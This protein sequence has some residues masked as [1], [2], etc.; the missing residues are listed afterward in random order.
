M[1]SPPGCFESLVPLR[2]VLA[3]NEKPNPAQ[4]LVP[5]LSP[6]QGVSLL[7]DLERRVPTISTFDTRSK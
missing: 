1:I 6:H 5:D 3:Y 2:I 7:L 4:L